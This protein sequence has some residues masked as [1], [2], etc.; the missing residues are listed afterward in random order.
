MLADFQQYLVAFVR[1]CLILNSSLC[2]ID[3]FCSTINLLCKVL[4]F[5]SG[6]ILMTDNIQTPELV[7]FFV[8][9]SLEQLEILSQGWGNGNT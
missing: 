7:L 9:M 8:S 1:C 5:V 4:D 3:F 2:F 6:I